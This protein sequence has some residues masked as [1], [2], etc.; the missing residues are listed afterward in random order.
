[1]NEMRQS[2]GN[3]LEVSEKG[4]PGILKSWTNH[5][6]VVIRCPDFDSKGGLQG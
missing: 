5:G 1:M 2:F 3:H 6:C 4:M